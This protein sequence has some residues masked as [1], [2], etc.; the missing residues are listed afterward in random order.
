VKDD[1]GGD[2][3]AAARDEFDTLALGLARAVKG[4]GD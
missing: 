3:H 2:H 1:P 4:E